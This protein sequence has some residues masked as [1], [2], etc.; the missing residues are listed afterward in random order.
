MRKIY[1]KLIVMLAVLLLSVSVVIMSSYAWLVLAGNPAAT[2]IHVAIG[3]GNTI[4]TA[5]NIRVETED[6]TV[7]NYPGHF[8]DKLNFG[9][10]PGYE[11]LRN[12]GN[13]T[14]VSTSNG[15]D[16]FLPAYYSGN[17]PE[18]QSGRIPSGMIKDVSEFLVDSELSYANLNPEDQNDKEKIQK[19][20]YV[21]LDFWVASPGGDYT[22][23]V[24]TGEG[25][26]DGGSFVVD[27]MEPRKTDEGFELAR[28]GSSASAAV[29]IGFLANDLPLID[30]TMVKY[31]ES[32]YFDKRFTSL[33]GIYQEPDTGTAYLEVDRFTIYEPNGDYHPANGTL[34]GSYVITRPLGL[35]ENGIEEQ[36]VKRNLTVQRKSDWAAAANQVGTAIEQQFQTALHSWNLEEMT[37][38]KVME[39]FYA[40]TLQGQI[41]PYVSKGNFLKRTEDLYAQSADGAA[42][43][44]EL[45][46]I[47]NAGATEDVY[48][49]RL[50]RNVPQRI[51]MFIWLEG[52]DPDCGDSV[53]SAR[54]AVSVELAGS[55]L[56]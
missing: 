46:R 43:A 48:I 30:D 52:Q 39:K 8:S 38:A 35:S 33:R 44:A 12:L 2:G 20:S 23:R 31:Q 1:F 25:T 16:W 50:E 53:D 26:S 37:P 4:L 27:L 14:P 47:E 29:R 54:F 15:I 51:R 3:G 9:M 45:S 22:V 21:Y 18:V 10:N 19:G 6:G 7:Y 28:S 17:D 49:I 11:Y 42:T 36:D 13:L 24:S 41:S 55:D 40:N 34:D 32:R 5:P 56:E